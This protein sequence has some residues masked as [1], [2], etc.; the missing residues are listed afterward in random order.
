IGGS[1]DFGTTNGGSMANAY[2]H[3][4]PIYCIAPSGLYTSASPTTVL[5]TTKDSP[6]RTA[7]DLNGKRVAVTTL[8]DLMQAA[9][10]KWIDDNGGDSRTISYPEIHNGDLV[11]SL[12]AKRVDATVLLEPQLTDAKD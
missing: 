1:L 11:P 12:L 5:V 2:I 9:V 10:M 7:K 6:I 8:H 3:G 4:L